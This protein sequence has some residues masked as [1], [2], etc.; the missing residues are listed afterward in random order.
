MF[1]FHLDEANFIITFPVYK[2]HFE[3]RQAQKDY[4]KKDLEECNK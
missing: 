4:F 1:Y 2:L 3:S